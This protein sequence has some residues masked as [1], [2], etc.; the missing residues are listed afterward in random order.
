MSDSSF[1]AVSTSMF[2]VCRADKP[3]DIIRTEVARDSLKWE[4]LQP[5]S[6]TNP[7]DP[8]SEVNCLDWFVH[9]W[10][11]KSNFRSQNPVLDWL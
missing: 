10:N 2:V 4:N 7:D 5:V 6:V 1:T 3:R 9:T 11:G 8:R